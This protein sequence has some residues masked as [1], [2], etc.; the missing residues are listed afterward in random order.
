MYE[1]VRG[2][3]HEGPAGFAII[4]AGGIG[5][6]VLVPRSTGARLGAPGSEVTLLL[7]H[8]INTEQGEQRLFGFATRR[9]REVFLALLEVKGIGPATALE[10]MS[11][12]DLDELV[13]LIVAG[14]TAGL[15]K[16]KGI[17]P[18]TAERLVT[19]L[20]DK[21]AP[22]ATAPGGQVAGAVKLPPGVAGADAVQALVALG[23]PAAKSE[24][25]VARAAEAL[26]AAA[27]TEALVRRALQ[28]V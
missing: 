6:R 19:E 12:A 17:G 2:R 21:L 3:L 4:E 26:G 16:F 8:T 25:A 11:A 18:K 22:L 14:N 24:A 1:F 28:L 9:E 10:V 13:N 7:H 23:Y 27:G 15:K 20:R 5:Y